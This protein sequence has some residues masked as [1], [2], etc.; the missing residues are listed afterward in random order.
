MECASAMDSER[1]STVMS[2]AAAH[3]SGG[4]VDMA[5]LP[6]IEGASWRGPG[7]CRIAGGNLRFDWCIL[8]LDLGKKRAPTC[9]RKAAHSQN[10]THLHTHTR[11]EH[12]G[13]RRASA[14]ER[15]R[16][17]SAIRRTHARSDHTLLARSA[18]SSVSIAPLAGVSCGVPPRSMGKS[19][20]L[21]KWVST[22]AR[23]RGM[24]PLLRVPQCPSVKTPLCLL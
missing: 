10:H 6:A 16:G 21:H 3:R 9:S 20:T 23:A 8:V 7:A 14:R 24:M 5:S 18:A 19:R 13:G 1:V 22:R 4:G 11:T 17:R 15:A 12:R 2:A